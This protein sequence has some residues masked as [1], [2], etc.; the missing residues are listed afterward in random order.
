MTVIWAAPLRQHALKHRT[1]H[2]YIPH[3]PTHEEW[4][5]VATTASHELS[6]NLDVLEMMPDLVSHS[7]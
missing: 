4:S 6:L 3:T 2:T 1:Q 7:I 5:M